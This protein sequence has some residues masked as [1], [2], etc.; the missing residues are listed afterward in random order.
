ML[1]AVA[2]SAAAQRG[3]LRLEIREPADGSVLPATSE[4]VKVQGA[5]SVFGAVRYLDLFLVMDTSKSL[6]RTDPKDF[7]KTGAIGLVESLPDRDGIQVGVVDF[8]RKGEL[9][10]P[11]TT[12]RDQVIEAL[13]ALDRSGSTDIAAG[14]QTALVGFEDR[15]RRGS[16]RVILLFTDGKTSDRKARQATE[17]ARLQGVAVHTVMLGKD[18]KASEMLAKLARGTR[19]SFVRVDDPQRLP[20][21]FLSLRTT[22]VEKVVLYVNGQH[23][24]TTRA[25]WRCAS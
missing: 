2:S 1:L 23:P 19:G 16:S 15:G 8:D 9:L 11:L 6:L 7:R 18:R 24:I 5:A 20:E 22:G 25:A 21:A 13:R 17:M 14:V 12:D 10:A 4:K 3:E